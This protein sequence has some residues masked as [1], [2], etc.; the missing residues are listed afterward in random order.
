[1]T[2]MCRLSNITD[3]ITDQEHGLIFFIPNSADNH[4]YSWVPGQESYSL[5]FWFIEESFK[6][7]S[8]TSSLSVA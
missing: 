2:Y 4:N 5:L 3:E 7:M 1:M 6:I 8:N